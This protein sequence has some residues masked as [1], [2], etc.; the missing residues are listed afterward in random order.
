MVKT[1]PR[2]VQFIEK[3]NNIGGNNAIGIVD[4]VE[5]RLVGMKSSGV[6]ETPGGTILYE[7]HRDLE[8]S[9]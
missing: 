5:N 1:F 3:L 7:A 4:M 6:Y 9:V 2:T 8:E